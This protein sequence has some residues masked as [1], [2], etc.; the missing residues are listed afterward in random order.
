MKQHAIKKTLLERYP[1][2]SDASFVRA[3]L[4][5]GLKLSK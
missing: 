4:L 1:A 3:A 2:L 5:R